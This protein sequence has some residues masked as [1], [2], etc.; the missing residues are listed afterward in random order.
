MTRDEIEL[1]LRRNRSLGST[2]QAKSLL[3]DVESLVRE[4]QAEV[5]VV[6]EILPPLTEAEKD[7]DTWETGESGL[8]TWDP[9]APDTAKPGYWSG[10]HDGVIQSAE[11]AEKVA[12]A[13][14]GP[15]TKQVANEIADQ[16]RG[17]RDS[18]Q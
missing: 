3:D 10:Y 12:A 15:K 6:R 7:I 1:R 13:Q 14:A 9:D 11:V 8:P 4:A 16:V 5:A 17:L 2:H 18:I